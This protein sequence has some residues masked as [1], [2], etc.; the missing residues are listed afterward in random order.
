LRIAT[1]N[2]FGYIWLNQKLNIMK[3][4]FLLTLLLLFSTS[5]F[6]HF[7]VT[8]QASV[9]NISNIE[10][11]TLTPVAPLA[12]GGNSQLVALILCFFVGILGVHRFYL[13][14]TLEGVIQLLTAGVFGIWTLIDFIMLCTGDLGPGW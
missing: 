4:L 11:T 12:S 5:S 7:P 10:T 8:K 2:L 6:A 14:D 3:K 1:V 9:E 13:G